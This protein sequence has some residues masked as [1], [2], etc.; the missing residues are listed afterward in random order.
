M[1]ETTE[2][3]V[4]WSDKYFD[5][6]SELDC[7]EIGAL[8]GLTTQYLSRFFKRVF[9]I[10]PWDGRQQGVPSKY[11]IFINNT[12]HLDNVFHCRTGSESFE[13]REFLDSVLDLKLA[14]TFIDGLHTPE[15]VVNDWD[16]CQKF[17]IQ[18]GIIFI[19]D[20]DFQPVNVG[21]EYVKNMSLETYE[22]IEPSR[23]SLSV[24]NDSDTYLR[25]FRKK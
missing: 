12:K 1:I 20:C 18:N 14:F 5:T 21:A 7:L 25:I 11:D 6:F 17:M 24:W 15:A 22:E 10:D 3:T 23:K 9:V 16:L 13:A 4:R 19:D 8:D 2:H